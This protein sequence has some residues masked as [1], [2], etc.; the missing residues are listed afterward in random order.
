MTIAIWVVSSTILLVFIVAFY[1]LFAPK[2]Q[3]KAAF[4]K[5]ALADATSVDVLLVGGGAMSTTL[6]M[7]LQQLDSKQ[8]ICMIEKLDQ[9]A[10][11]S[12]NALNNAGTGHAGNCE[13]NY[14]PE[15]PDGSIN[16]TKALKINASFEVSL[17]FWAHLVEKGI[18][19][20][21]EN[22]IKQVPHLS[23]VFG[24]AD[25]DFLKRRFEQLRETVAFEDMEYSEDHEC[26]Q[27]WFPLIMQ[28]RPAEDKLAATRIRYGTDVNFGALARSMA[29]YLEKQD[30]FDLRM[31]RVVTDL[32]QQEDKR[33]LVAVKDLRTGKQEVVN[34]G[35]VFLGAGGGA[36][37]LLQK[38]GIPEGNG[39]GGFP[40]G[41]QWLI[42]DKP[43]IVKQHLA[44][45]Y[46]KASLGA[47]PMSVPHLDTRT[48]DGQ[49]LLLFGP[50]AGFTTKYLK[51][52][53]FLDLFKSVS[54]KNIWP[55]LATARDNMDLTIYLI[56]EVLQ[57]PKARCESL[58][59]F[60]PNIRPE[61]WKLEHAGK[62]VQIIKRD[63]ERG[64]RL[65]FGTEVVSAGDGTLAALL[66][67]SPGASTTVQTM[68]D[69]LEECFPEQIKSESWQAALKD[70]IPSYGQDLL[71][72]DELFRQVRKHDLAVLRLDEL[73]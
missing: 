16:T 6:G 32:H 69:V 35:F 38:S 26:L 14:T 3:G 64:G 51:K 66:G 49:N 63:A 34:A 50:F 61:D 7:L 13:L 73:P 23:L 11:E 68:L 54:I 57:S 47:P 17:Q 20:T 22:F 46:G 39:F 29:A 27:K 55:M 70:M 48:I 62:R 37:P 41:G 59:R 8:K 40:V 9:I 67:A 53:S 19:S 15:N 58:K 65:Q 4:S 24:D 36:L 33:W 1:V 43:E 12:T 2:S 28:N 52:G 72:E 25:I 18:L 31:G 45:V 60:Y 42:C 44:K 30:N 5:K 21:P 71:E 56:K 10:L